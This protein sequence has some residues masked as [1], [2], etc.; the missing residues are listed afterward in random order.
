MTLEL[1]CGGGLKYLRHTA[2][3]MGSV[4]EHRGSLEV[5]IHY[6]HDPR[7]PPR[8]ARRL[9]DWV[10]DRGGEL[11]LVAV[12]R[13]RL[14]GL[15]GRGYLPTAMW[16]RVFLPELAPELRRVLYLDADTVAM[17]SL[18]PL[19]ATGLGDR[20]VAAVANVPD[21]WTAPYFESLALPTPYFNSGVLVMDLDRMRADG[22]QRRIVEFARRD[23]M[24]FGDQDTLNVVL[25]GERAELDPRWNVMN[26]F[27]EY[28]DAAV[29]LF[30]RKQLEAA[31]SRPGIRHF[32]GPGPN[33][34]WHV[35]CDRSDAAAYLH[36]RRMTPWPRRGL[37]ERWGR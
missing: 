12:D 15:E 3:M 24:R 33:K 22:Y 19:W 28:P 27:Y 5:R 13:E 17:D 14:Q 35:R 16:H 26:S 10:A 4:L 32:E 2:T 9:R 8:V 37:M 31:L 21:P 36:H 6:L 11:A 7:L 29:A 18:E 23:P 34:P 20:P 1:A 30:G 25:S